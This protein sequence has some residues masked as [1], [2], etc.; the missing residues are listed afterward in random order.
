[1]VLTRSWTLTGGIAVRVNNEVGWK[2]KSFKISGTL[3]Q[4][5]YVHRCACAQ[6]E[7]KIICVVLAHP[8]TNE[9]L[10]RRWWWW[11]CWRS[12][13]KATG[14]A[15]VLYSRNCLLYSVEF[16]QQI[17]MITAVG[18]F[19]VCRPIYLPN[20]HEYE[21]DRMTGARQ[22]D[23]M[24]NEI[25]RLQLLNCIRG[26]SL[27][28]CMRDDKLYIYTNTQY[29]TG[30][31]SKNRTLMTWWQFFAAMMAWFNCT[32]RCQQQ[33]HHHH[34]DGVRSTIYFSLSFGCFV[35]LAL[36]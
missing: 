32:M 22:S 27:A 19:G 25:T 8:V 3:I 13:G 12:A 9:Q 1:M 2:I 30:N 20:H 14:C 24:K 29:A 5:A 23:Q 11:Y 18:I 34:H 7:L 21:F 17:I 31:N 4:F 28:V 35:C 16:V 33:H 36:I 15:N 26:L 10:F 6:T